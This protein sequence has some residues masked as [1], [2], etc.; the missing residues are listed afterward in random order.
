MCVQNLYR[1][2]NREHSK[3]GTATDGRTFAFCSM[4][5]TIL[6]K[7]ALAD[8]Y[9]HEF[10]TKINKEIQLFAKSALYAKCSYLTFMHAISHR[11][12][13]F[14]IS[15]L[16]SLLF[17]VYLGIT[18]RCS[19]RKIRQTYFWRS[20]DFN[21]IFSS[22]NNVVLLLELQFYIVLIWYRSG[23]KGC[24]CFEITNRIRR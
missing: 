21:L 5:N 18:A 7:S 16:C 8:A 9:I 20:V 10:T 1:H 17:F 15:V 4:Q 12:G 22:Y 14:C 6:S 13:W 11:K 19:T 23:I 2:N 3:Y 24:F